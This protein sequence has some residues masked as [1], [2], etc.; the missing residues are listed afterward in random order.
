MFVVKHM[1]E[2]NY[3]NRRFFV[4]LFLNI[5]KTLDIVRRE[6]VWKS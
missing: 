3:E 1:Q 2:K 5:V 4:M 6:K